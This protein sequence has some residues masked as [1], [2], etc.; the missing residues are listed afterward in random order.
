MVWFCKR[1]LCSHIKANPDKWLLRSRVARRKAICSVLKK[2][3]RDNNE[4]SNLGGME[5][6]DIYSLLANLGGTG[7]RDVKKK[8][9]KEQI[10][11]LR[12][13]NGSVFVSKI[14]IGILYVRNIF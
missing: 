14:P 2:F 11:F 6:P 9:L 7:L 8:I 1:C 3:I 4:R 5:K 10:F 13:R 12:D